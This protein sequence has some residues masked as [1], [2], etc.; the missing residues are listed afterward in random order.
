MRSSTH[1][2]LIPSYNTGRRLVE[3]VGEALRHWEPIWVVLDG[4]T[5][6]SGEAIGALAAQDPRI[7]VIVRPRRGGKGAAIATGLAVARAEGFTHILTMDA[8]GQHPAARIPDFMAASAGQP[9][10]LVL[11]RPLFGPEAPAARLKGRRVSIWLVRIEVLGLAIAD[12]LFGFRVYPTA[13]LQRAFRNTPFGRGYDFDQEMAVRI[14]WAGA[15]T[16]NLDAACRYL[17]KDEG[18]ISH[19]RYLRD[20]LILSW[21]NFRLLLELLLR[22]PFLLR[23]RAA[24]PRQTS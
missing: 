22:W 3:T 5:D 2:I 18:G 8:D 10:A 21:M 24:S 9:Q 12:P 7:R 15:P 19:F 17:A 6:G 23:R 16:L 20:N 4:S 13:A 11:G 1:L 14:V